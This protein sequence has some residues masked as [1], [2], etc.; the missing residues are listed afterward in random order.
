[1]GRRPSRRQDAAD[2]ASIRRRRQTP[3]LA[4]PQLNSPL[5]GPF[6]GPA[7]GQVRPSLPNNRRQRPKPAHAATLPK[8][9]TQRHPESANRRRRVT[10]PSQYRRSRDNHQRDKI[11]NSSAFD[12]PIV[13]FNSSDKT[14]GVQPP[15]IAQI[16]KRRLFSP[17]LTNSAKVFHVYAIFYDPLQHDLRCR[18]RLVAKI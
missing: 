5:G 7:P 12:S 18:T 13:A 15:Y 3:P 4:D 16:G 8:V 9:R 14:S 10:S 1:M 6:E 17:Q 2:P 11:Q